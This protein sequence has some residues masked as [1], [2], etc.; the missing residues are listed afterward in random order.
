MKLPSRIVLLFLIPVL[1]GCSRLSTA[2]P[3]AP[4]PSPTLSP[5]G[6]STFQAPDP[7]RVA[8]DY[9]G[10]WAR[11]DYPQMYALLDQQSRAAQSEQEFAAY[12]DGIAAEAALNRVETRILAAQVQT[13]AAHVDYRVALHSALV[14]ELQRDTALELSLENGQWRVRWDGALVLPELGGGNSLRLEYRIPARASLYDRNG[15]ALVA[16]ADAFALGIFPDQVSPEQEDMLLAQLGRLTGRHPDNIRG[17]Y[18]DFP[19]GAGWYLPL[20]EVRADLLEGGASVLGGFPGLVKSPFHARLYFEGG[21]A[22]HLVGYVGSIPAEEAAAYR[23]LGYRPEER[24]GLAGL[25]RWGEAT[26]AGKRGGS[27]SVVSP[28]GEIVARLAEISPAPAQDIFTT[29]DKDLQL[30]VQRALEGLRGAVVVLERETGRVLAMA[31]SPG[32]DPN[33]FEPANLNS[34]FQ[35]EALA[36]PETTPLLN[37]ATLGQYPPGSVFKIITMAAALESGLYTPDTT[38]D[39][40]YD[41]TEVQGITSHDWTWEHFQEDGRTPPSGTLTLPEGLMRSCD[42]FF[43]HIG[44]D[45]FRRGLGATLA[46]LARGFGLGSPSGF[47][48]EEEEGQI[49]APES[50]VDAFNFA[51]GQGTTLVTP[52]QVANFVAAVGNGGVLYTPQLVERIAP[53]G[54]EATFVFQPEARGRLPVSPETLAILQRAMVSVVEDRRG[55]AWYRLSTLNLK[56]AGKTGTSQDPPRDPHAWFAGYTFEGR[57][58]RPDIAVA[59]VVENAGEG[60]DYALP[61][62]RR[63]LEI[64][65]YGSPRAYYWWESNYGVARSTPEP[66]TAT[67]E[68]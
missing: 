50:E 56:V 10:A 31:S 26:L 13:R 52:L 32:F 46:D 28:N 30:G 23:R 51:V 33:L 42:P 59:V 1:S 54:G 18:A 41:F 43:M 9:L 19:E 25:E 22:P 4:R 57:A 27:L 17:M 45:L 16:E 35:A 61:V 15:Q 55:T 7:E 5:P 62:F 47:V 6:V 29:L 11:E 48:L 34:A 65:F 64:Y 63:A 21:I 49:L 39:C 67:P 58:D 12:Y 36:N 3:P 68:P 24:V 8:R 53:P 2:T 38:Y 66:E 60:A 14:G 37:R 40:G 44:V 20:T